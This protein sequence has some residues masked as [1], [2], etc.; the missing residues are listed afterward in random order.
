[1][2]SFRRA[3]A[4]KTWR[5][6]RPRAPNSVPRRNI[7]A[8]TIYKPKTE[9]WFTPIVGLV[10]IFPVFTFAL[11]SW[12]L[13]RL[14]WK[15]DLIDELTEKL[16]LDPLPLPRQVNISVLPEFTWR[17]VKAKGKWDHAHTMLLGPKVFEG[18]NGYQVIT[19]LMRQDGSTVL[20]DRGFVPKELGDSGTFDKPEGE[21]EVVGLIRLSQPR[22]T[23]TPDNDPKEKFW[24]WRDLDAMA[25]YAGGK[26]ANVQ[27]VFFEEIFDG[28]TGQIMERLDK[29]IPVGRPAT[30]NLRNSHLSYVLTWWGLSAI[31]SV[32]LFRF[33]KKNRVRGRS[34]PR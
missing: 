30:V 8:P 1:M 10:A 7:T 18:E 33:I 25:E 4:S 26:E 6:P 31:S 24:Y 19:P 16:Q 34:L 21:V 20:V 22:N 17:K 27:P 3:F 29:G 15:I 5:P 11:G 14:K 2:F 32:M 23:F 9:S 12:Q 28:H 13:K